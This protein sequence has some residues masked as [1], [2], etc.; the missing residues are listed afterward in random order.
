[1]K[2]KRKKIEWKPDIN[3][4]MVMRKSQNYKPSEELKK[5]FERGV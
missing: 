5:R 2:M 3:I 4:T 1:M